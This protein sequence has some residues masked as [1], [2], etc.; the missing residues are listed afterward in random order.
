VKQLRVNELNIFS[1]GMNTVSAPYMLSSDESSLLV[2]VDIR[3]GELQSIPH[4]TF[5]KSLSNVQ[6]FDYNNKV[7]EYPAWRSNVV[8]DNTWYWTD[9]AQAGKVLPDGTERSLGLPTPTLR[10]TLTTESD[11]VLQGEYRYCYTFV[12]TQTGTESAP[13]PMSMYMNVNAEKIVVDNFSD[14][15]VYANAY[16]IYRIGGYL[17]YFMLVDEVVPDS[18]N[19][20]F[21][22]NFDDT[23]IRGDILNTL[24]NGPPPQGIHYLT[25][26]N[27]RM[28]AAEG[29]KLYYSAVGNPDSWYVFDYIV[30]KEEIFGLAKS[31]NGL[32]V[33]GDTWSSILI[34][35]DPSNF[36]VKVLSEEVGLKNPQSI[37]YI[38]SETIW[39]SNHGLVLS[40]GNSINQ[41]TSDKIEEMSGMVATGAQ[42]LNNIYYMSFKPELYPSE[43]LFPRESLW[44][45]G[46]NGTAGVDQGIAVLDFKRGR[47]YSYKII[48]HGDIEYLDKVDGTIGITRG[49]WATAVFDCGTSAFEDCLGFII[50]SGFE[51]DYLNPDMEVDLS[52]VKNAAKITYLSPLLIDGTNS[53][54]K[55]YEHV[56]LLFR[57]IFNIKIYF[58]NDR[59]IQEVTIESKNAETYEYR[60]IGIPNE[61]DKA[62]SIRFKIEGRG[63]IKGIQYAFK[64]RELN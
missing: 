47:G 3:K 24:R 13:S 53:T 36:R 39:L 12:D 31:P 56:R 23:Q 32:I 59:L 38:N 45:N 27:G 4:I 46:V 8:W 61:D 5:K 43:S 10:P 50:C 1:G 17:P 35:N 54:L 2:N 19:L 41:L 63:S 20:P 28:Y 37:S 22:D 33:M 7:Y 21:K 26:L 51:L 60:K 30:F 57:G 55:E 48:D 16:R 62:Y 18:T 40:D 25:E 29:N 44:P 42:V 34:G 49:D 58:D 11:G 64:Y 6:W 15:P 52:N 9:G 14:L